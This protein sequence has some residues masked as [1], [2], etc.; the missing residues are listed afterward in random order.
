MIQSTT[1]A[2]LR[3]DLKVERVVSP[4]EAKG[5]PQERKEYGGCEQLQEGWMLAGG[6]RSGVDEAGPGSLTGFLRIWD[7]IPRAMGSQCRVLNRID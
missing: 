1:S 3:R 6:E 2:S 4:E 5:R 7:F